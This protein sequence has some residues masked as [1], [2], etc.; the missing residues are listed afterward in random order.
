MQ[1]HENNISEKS[2]GITNDYDHLTSGRCLLSRQTAL[3]S[4]WIIYFRL[5]PSQNFYGQAGDLAWLFHFCSEIDQDGR[6]GSKAATESILE[7][8]QIDARRLMFSGA[9]QD[10]S[11]M[12]GIAS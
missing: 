6:S 9:W 5:R 1:A 12:P 7:R 4:H 10:I 3:I 11:L 2:L 8:G